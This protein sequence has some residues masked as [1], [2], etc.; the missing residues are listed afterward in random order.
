MVVYI[1]LLLHN[2][3][4]VVNNSTNIFL[5]LKWYYSALSM[6]IF[7]LLNGSLNTGPKEFN[8]WQFELRHTLLPIKSWLCHH[9]Y[10]CSITDSHTNTL[11]YR[12]WLEYVYCSLAPLR[13]KKCKNY[14]D[15]LNCCKN[16]KCLYFHVNANRQILQ[17][18]QLGCINIL[19]AQKGGTNRFKG[20]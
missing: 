15:N 8:I 16:I 19:V 11:S 10:S 5:S 18:Y 14:L 13:Q 9:I 17:K 4:K 1:F 2:N 3:K 12:V 20:I 6:P 7:P